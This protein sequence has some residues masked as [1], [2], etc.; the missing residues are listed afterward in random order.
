MDNFD[1][2]GSRIRELKKIAPKKKLQTVDNEVLQAYAEGSKVV[3]DERKS[4]ATGTSIYIKDGHTADGET[5]D[6]VNLILD[7]KK[8]G[9]TRTHKSLTRK[10]VGIA[11]DGY[12][13][14]RVRFGEPYLIDKDSPE[15]A[16]SY[17]EG[18]EYDIADGEQKYYYPILEV[19]D[20]RD[21][22]KPITKHGNYAQ[23]E[24][25]DGEDD[26]ESDSD[27]NVIPLSQRFNESNDD[28]R[29]SKETSESRIVRLKED[30]NVYAMF[31]GL[32]TS[33]NF[34]AVRNP[35]STQA[36]FSEMLSAY[37]FLAVFAAFS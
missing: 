1:A 7:G 22:P 29:Y 27:G 30:I 9:E 18:T 15:Y 16:D 35:S 32:K 5:V 37:A 36:S 17:I 26:T 8:K 19:E 28:I 4:L 23:Y 2:I 14:G 11:K 13:Y 31:S 24:Y 25:E 33:S 6:F 21:N 12:V 34:S 3:E 20:F 10:W